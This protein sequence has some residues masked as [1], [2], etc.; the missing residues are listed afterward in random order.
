MS[1]M[2]APQ[3]WACSPQ[4]PGWP[5]RDEVGNNG[6]QS[7]KTSITKYDRLGGLEQQTLIVSQLWRLN[8]RDEVVPRAGFFGSLSPSLGDG[9]LLPG[10]SRDLSMCRSVSS[11]P[12]LEGHQSYW[13]RVHSNDLIWT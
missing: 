12:F 10:D 13:I 5:G 6:H 1:A 7:A 2:L 9:H 8:V 4:Q 11:F 3:V